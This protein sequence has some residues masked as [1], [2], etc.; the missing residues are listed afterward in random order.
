MSW[1]DSIFSIQNISSHKYSNVLQ[2][3]RHSR[4]SFWSHGKKILF[5][6]QIW[7]I[8]MWHEVN[9]KAAKHHFQN[10]MM[11]LR[12]RFHLI[13]AYNLHNFNCTLHQIG[14]DRIVSVC[15]V[16]VR[17][18]HRQTVV[19]MQVHQRLIIATPIAQSKAFIKW[20]SPCRFWCSNMKLS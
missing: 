4:H 13:N 11:W 8:C 6:F 15:H 7:M 19:L 17:V 12:E 20:K 14:S 1:R 2:T 5:K 18:C 10:A 3:W 9:A 16:H